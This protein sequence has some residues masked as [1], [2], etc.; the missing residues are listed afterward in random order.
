MYHVEVPKGAETTPVM[1]MTDG[2]VTHTLHLLFHAQDRYRHGILVTHNKCD[3]EEFVE[4]DA[5]WEYEGIT[6]FRHASTNLLV[7]SCEKEVKTW[8]GEAVADA[9][10][11]FVSSFFNRFTRQLFIQ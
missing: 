4:V 5:E 3:H 6:V 2:K 7:L 11:D 10:Y 8:V 1:E 9:I